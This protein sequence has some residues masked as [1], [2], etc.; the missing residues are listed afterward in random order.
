MSDQQTISKKIDTSKW[1][2]ED[3]YNNNIAAGM[4]ESEARFAAER[5]VGDAKYV[6]NGVR[7]D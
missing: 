6:E 2:V 7:Y 4:T 5:A 3:W 1:T